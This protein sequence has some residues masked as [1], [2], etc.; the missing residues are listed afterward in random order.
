[1]AARIFLYLIAIVIVLVLLAGI[2]W[3]LFQD[4]LL[5]MALVP[6]DTI[7]M[8]EE[9]EDSAYANRAMWLARPDIENPPSDWLPEGYVDYDADEIATGDAA[10]ADGSRIPVFYVLPTTYLDRDRWNAPIRSPAAL[11]RQQ[12][13]AASQASVF[14]R[15]GDIWAP[16]YRQAVVGAFLTSHRNAEVALR[17]A[18]QDVEAAFDYF[19]SEIG[20]EQPFVIA[21]HS[22]GGLHLTTLLHERIAGTPLADRIAAA[23]L[24]GWPISVEADLPALPLPACE[25]ASSSG[26]IVAF[27]S[28][29]EPADPHQ[30]TRIYDE[31]TGYTGAPRRDT[32]MLCVNPLT[33]RADGDA[34]TADAN[35]GAIVPND[36]MN[37]ARLA[38]GL[39]SARC[40]E[41]GLLLVGQPPGEFGRYVLPGNNYH[42]FDFLLFWSN[43]RADVER[44]V[45]AF[46]E[47]RR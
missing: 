15:I 37:D 8:L 27:Q 43:L 32:A 44:R 3:T 39:V 16:L 24:I 19:L 9:V 33:G 46:A 20:E 28:F 30:I 22:Q 34:A 31:S 5:E 40:D 4:E 23:Y 36:A 25:R 17:F 29:A 21:G 1:M 41:R 42:V 47:A 7:E 45:A 13:F 6:G 26:C 11:E 10:Q 35:L 38:P 14:N 18:Y 2:A 12:L